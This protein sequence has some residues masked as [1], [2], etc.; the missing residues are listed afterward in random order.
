[1]STPAGSDKQPQATIQANSQKRQIN[2]QNPNGASIPRDWTQNHLE[3]RA[4]L[5]RSLEGGSEKAGGANFSELGTK[6]LRT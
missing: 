5:L 4:E 1:M 3:G 6:V 2:T